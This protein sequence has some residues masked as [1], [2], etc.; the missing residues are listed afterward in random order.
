MLQEYLRRIGL[1]LV[2]LLVSAIGITLMLQANIGLEPWS[3]LQQG[4]AKTFGITYGTAASIVG[5]AVIAI[6]YFCGESFGL[7]TL[8]NI[9]VCPIFIDI[10]LYLNWIPLFERFSTGLAALLIG[11]ADRHGAA[12]SGD[13]DVYEK[14]LRLRSSRCAHGRT[15]P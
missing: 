6:A 11:A 13:M 9:F 2:G 5:A 14:H 15:G 12:G 4:I 8:A 1:L 10:L 7:G 3:V